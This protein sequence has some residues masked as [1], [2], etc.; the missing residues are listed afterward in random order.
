MFDRNLCQTFNLIYRG[1]SIENNT[2]RYFDLFVKVIIYI[3]KKRNLNL[4][5]VSRR[6]HKKIGQHPFDHFLLR[7]NNL[8]KY[9]SDLT[10]ILGNIFWIYILIEIIWIAWKIFYRIWRWVRLLPAR[11]SY[12]WGRVST[13]AWGRYGS[14]IVWSTWI[15]LNYLFIKMK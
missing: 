15:S 13:I 2:Y 12:P 9:L 4:D 14:N 11:P 3:S 1:D 7:H 8:P 6:H 5:R 10:K